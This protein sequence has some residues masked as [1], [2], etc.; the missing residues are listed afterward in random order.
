LPLRSGVA[1][2]RFL[3]AWLAAAPRGSAIDLKP[4]GIT[5][6]KPPVRNISVATP[7]PTPNPTT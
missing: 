1:G 4:F 3:L 5:L 7:T 2:R 6:N